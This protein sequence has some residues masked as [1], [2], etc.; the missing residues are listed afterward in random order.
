VVTLHVAALHTAKSNAWHAFAYW[1]F[2][3]PV[4]GDP[5]T[6]IVAGHVTLHLLSPTDH[7]LPSQNAGYVTLHAFAY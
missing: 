7:A 2:A 6:G 1:Q 5:F 4:H 3:S